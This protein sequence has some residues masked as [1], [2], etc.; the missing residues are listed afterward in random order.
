MRAR[1]RG[2]TG[3]GPR[4]RPAWPHW[5]DRRPRARSRAPGRARLRPRARRAGRRRRGFRRWCAWR[6]RARAAG[7][8]S[9]AA[10]SRLKTSTHV[11]TI[12][13]MG[14]MAEGRASR[15]RGGVVRRTCFGLSF[16]GALSLAAVVLVLVVVSV[17]RLQDLARQENEAD[18]RVTAELLA[19]ALRTLPAASEPSLRDLVRR[20]EL[21]GGLS[22]AEL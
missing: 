12:R 15:A 4:P 5:R 14:E 13:P 3:R 6:A 22:D 1:P 2:S 20:P 10:S 9:R 16:S 7:A 18:A 19:R 21:S 11:R 8:A 17:P